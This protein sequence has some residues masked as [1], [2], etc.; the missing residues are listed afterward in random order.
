MMRW[1]W[2]ILMLTAMGAAL[3]GLRRRQD[4]TR[5]DIHRL[6]GRLYRVRRTLWDQ[7]PRLSEG[8]SAQR[9]ERDWPT[10]SLRLAPPG[11]DPTGERVA[12]RQR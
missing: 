5:A 11:A 1:V 12:G 10:G 9:I 6:E 4:A 7:E 3:T 8:M 2:V